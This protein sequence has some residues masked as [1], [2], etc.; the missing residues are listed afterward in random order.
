[1]NRQ[2]RLAAV[3]G[4]SAVQDVPDVEIDYGRFKYILMRLRD[5][6]GNSKLIVRG[7]R[8]KEYHADILEAVQSEI[9]AIGLEVCT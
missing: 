5:R 1:M 3:S 7:D 8:E 6:E 9:K 2:A 4:F